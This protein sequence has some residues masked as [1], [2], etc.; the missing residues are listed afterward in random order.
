MATTS[1][2]ET[3]NKGGPERSREIY[4][5]GKSRGPYRLK[6]SVNESLQESSTEGEG[7]EVSTNSGMCTKYSFEI[8]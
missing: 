5:A 3:D 1:T 4:M 6:R 7:S 8:C 2:F